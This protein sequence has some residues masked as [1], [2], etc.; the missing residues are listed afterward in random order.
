MNIQ[1]FQLLQTYSKR[2]RELDRL[3]RRQ[4]SLISILKNEYANLR[5]I[6]KEKSSE[7]SRIDLK[8]IRK[9]YSILKLPKT[10]QK[11]QKHDEGN[12]FINGWLKTN[13]KNFSPKWEELNE[14]RKKMIHSG[15]VFSKK[16]TENKSPQSIGRAFSMQIDPKREMLK[17]RTEVGNFHSSQFLRK[18]FAKQPPMS[19]K[20]DERKLNLSS[21]TTNNTPSFIQKNC[22]Y[23]PKKFKGKE[24][25]F[26]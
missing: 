12:I 25:A 23:S 10:E 20:S 18:N 3:D 11:I 5:K 9:E 16:N 26:C 8:K 21:F 24:R 14:K 22:C 19:P 15:N 4:S 2:E 13:F 17:R 6:D 7:K 1:N